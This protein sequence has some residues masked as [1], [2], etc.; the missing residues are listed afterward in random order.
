MRRPGN[1]R[2]GIRHRD[3][4]TYARVTTTLKRIAMTQIRSLIVGTALTAFAATAAVAQTSQTAQPAVGVGAQTQ[5]Q[6]QGGAGG[7]P[8]QG[9]QVAPP[10]AQAMQ[11]DAAPAAQGVQAPPPSRLTASG[12]PDPLVQ[13]RDADAQA[14]AEYRASKKASKAELKAQQK[15]AKD[16][17]KAQ[18]RGAKLNQKADK[19]TANNEMKMDM[20]GQAAAQADGADVKH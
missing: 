5:L 8:A 7:A 20:Q 14:N 12:S 18:V 10:S 6:T 2:N 9:L 4:G 16:Q 3:A 17:Y 13:K 1:A 15:A 19:Q 11:P